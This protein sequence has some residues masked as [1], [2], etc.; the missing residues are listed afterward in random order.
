MASLEGG[1]PPLV[2]LVVKNPPTKA[3]RHNRLGFD[4]WVGKIPWR[5][6]WQPAPEFLPGESPWTEEPGRLRKIS[7][8]RKWQ[9]APEFLPGKFQGQRSLA[10]AVVHRVANTTDATEDT[11]VLAELPLQAPSHGD[12][13]SRRGPGSCLP[14][15]RLLWV[16]AR[17]SAQLETTAHPASAAGGSGSGHPLGH[18]GP[19]NQRGAG[20]SRVRE[21]RSVR[22]GPVCCHA[23]S[24]QLS[25][26]TACLR[27]M[28][29]TSGASSVHFV[30]RE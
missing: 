18:T 28:P 16:T 25:Q 7:W 27:G 22:E 9:P 6:K 8:R 20:S 17:S 24:L 4:P 10:E 5:R 3:S 13:A 23:R 12:T 2:T 21:G 14:T 1:R 26:E 30:L 11:R 19:V 15:R 29:V